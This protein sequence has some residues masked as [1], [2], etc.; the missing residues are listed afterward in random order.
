MSVEEKKA[1]LACT[2][3]GYLDTF[4]LLLRSHRLG[5]D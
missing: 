4:P 3:F 1:G 5:L 2:H